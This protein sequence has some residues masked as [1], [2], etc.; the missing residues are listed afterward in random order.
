MLTNII[1]ALTAILGH[2][3]W[4]E[5]NG[6]TLCK[7]SVRHIEA[8]NRHTGAPAVRASAGAAG[9]AREIK[10]KVDLQM[11]SGII[12]SYQ[13]GCLGP[14]GSVRQ[15]REMITRHNMRAQ[16]SCTNILVGTRLLRSVVLDTIDP[17]AED[18]VL[19]VRDTTIMLRGITPAI[20]DE[21]GTVLNRP[22]N[23]TVKIPLVKFVRCSAIKG[24]QV[25]FSLK[26]L[27]IFVGLAANVSLA[28]APSNG[29][30]TSIGSF[31]TMS[32][33]GA[34]D[35][36]SATVEL[37]VNE[38]GTRTRFQ[39]HHGEKQGPETGFQFMFDFISKST[40]ESQESEPA[41]RVAKRRKLP[42]KN[43]PQEVDEEDRD[44]DDLFVPTQEPLT[45]TLRTN[46]GAA[47]N[48][49]NEEEPEDD[50]ELSANRSFGKLIGRSVSSYRNS[51]DYYLSQLLASRH[52]EPR[53]STRNKK[54][55][56]GRHAHDQDPDATFDSYD[57]Q[58]ADRE[59]GDEQTVNVG[60]NT[61]DPVRDGGGD[62]YDLQDEED[63]EEGHGIQEL[64]TTG[65]RGGFILEELDEE[66]GPTQQATNTVAR[67]LFD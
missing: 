5:S 44:N 53:P 14:M 46:A 7:I 58:S 38:S 16:G 64:G 41:A 3:R 50:D 24:T 21:T 34:D 13:L 42:R 22:R 54:L 52:D 35:I 48:D 29:T 12:K 4:G 39:S 66:I 62:D 11:A 33:Q 25:Q 65:L 32:E 2:M 63:E 15:V 59:L 28:S 6:T 60:W 17:R 19:M 40:A 27:R 8:T 45:D 23:T 20:K 10:M 55:V 26:P 47:S 31:D 56:G 51:D 1:Q 9:E 43:D 57:T 30:L 37:L 36:G 67:G 61:Q 18:F 49:E